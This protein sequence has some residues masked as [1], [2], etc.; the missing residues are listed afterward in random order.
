MGY[1]T[2][3]RLSV[4]PKTL[5]GD[6][7]KAIL[8][9]IDG[10]QMGFEGDLDFGLT[11]WTKWYYYEKDMIAL[12]KK[13]PNL[14]FELY[15]DGEDGDDHWVCYF[16]NGDSQFCFG[17]IVYE[18]CPLSKAVDR[19]VKNSLKREMESNNDTSGANQ[20]SILAP[21]SGGLHP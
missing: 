3:Y 1:Y 16:Q 10:L 11:T 4:Y 6:T 9:E 14:I 15:G 8:G 7:R 13:F 12:S 2:D 5:P 20:I 17:S 19:I 18:E 21:P